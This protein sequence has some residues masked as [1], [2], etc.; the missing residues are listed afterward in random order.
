M[1]WLAWFVHIDIRT[2]LH[3]RIFL[4]SLATTLVV[5]SRGKL[6]IFS[7]S[8]RR[9][10]DL[11]Y[12][13]SMSFDLMKG[14]HPPLPSTSFADAKVYFIPSFTMTCVS[15]EITR[16]IQRWKIYLQKSPSFQDCYHKDC[17]IHA[18]FCLGTCH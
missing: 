6:H 16:R 9:Q 13:S 11:T 17:W 14:I 1:L 4:P 10:V 7:S 15:L 18:V 8:F 5:S 12:R 2:E 3:T